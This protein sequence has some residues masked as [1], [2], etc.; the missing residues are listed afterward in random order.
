MGANSSAS[1]LTPLRPKYAF[2]IPGP[3]ASSVH[4]WKSASEDSGA[5]FPA[6]A[7]ASAWLVLSLPTM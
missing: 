2:M 5:S 3:P 4:F 6:E 1:T 7:M